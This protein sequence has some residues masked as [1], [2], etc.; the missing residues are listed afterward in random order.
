[1]ATGSALL[2]PSSPPG[3]VGG[4]TGGGSAGRR[5]RGGGG[6]AEPAERDGKDGHGRGGEDAPPE[7]Q[8][9]PRNVDAGDDDRDEAPARRGAGDDEAPAHERPGGPA[10]ARP[11]ELALAQ[12]D[13][14]DLP[15]QR[16]R[17]G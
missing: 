14:P 11:G 1:M 17:E 6:G 3:A 8:G 13:P 15:G 10:G 5:V 16:L 7:D 9:V 12:L 4:R 2:S